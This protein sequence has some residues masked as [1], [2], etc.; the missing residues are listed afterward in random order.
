MQLRRAELDRVPYYAG[1][2]AVIYRKDQTRLV[3]VKQDPRA[4]YAQFLTVGKEAG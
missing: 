1:A 3:G 4:T 2:R